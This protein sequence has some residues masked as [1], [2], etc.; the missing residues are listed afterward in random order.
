VE[1]VFPYLPLLDQVLVMTVEP[2]FGGQKFMVDM[3]DKVLNDSICNICN[4]FFC[5]II[6]ENT[7][8][9]MPK[10]EYTGRRRFRTGHNRYRCDGW[11]KYDRRGKCCI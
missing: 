1:S 4:C 3:M 7:S 6:G 9:E 10:F 11:S 2:G 5:G 8:I